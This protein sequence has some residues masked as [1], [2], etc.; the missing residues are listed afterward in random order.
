MAKKNKKNTKAYNKVLKAT[1]EYFTVML[2]KRGLNSEEYEFLCDQIEFYLSIYDG[3]H[4]NDLELYYS[5]QIN[6]LTK[7]NPF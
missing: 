7:T 2:R 4:K 6:W 5:I 1:I 3:K